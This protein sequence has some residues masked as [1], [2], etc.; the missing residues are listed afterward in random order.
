MAHNPL[1]LAS[2]L[3]LDDVMFNFLMNLLP[4]N[5][6]S[7]FRFRPYLA[8]ILGLK[9]G[10]GCEIRKNI[11]F[12][13]HRKIVLGNNVC[14]NRQSYFDA[15]AG[16]FIGDNVKFGP[17]ALIIAGSHEIGKPRMRLGE[18][19]SKKICI[20]EGCWICARVT[21]SAGVTIGA[22]SVVSA[23]SVVQRS[24]PPHRLIGGNPARALEALDTADEPPS[25]T[26]CPSFSQGPAGPASPLDIKLIDPK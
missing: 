5:K 11:Y 26:A 21:I 13:G 16:I 10:K 6:L 1:R 2:G 7:N 22:G 4:D 23:G 25:K 8:R 3:D 15:G 14:L 24:M 9:C 19:V 18:V 12:E 17:Q 20:E